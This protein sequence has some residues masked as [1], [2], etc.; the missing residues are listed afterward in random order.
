[1]AYLKDKYI[2]EVKTTLKQEY[3]SLNDHAIP[4]V[5]KVVVNMGVSDAKDNASILE[6]AV[7]NMTSLAGQKPVVTKAKR[8]ISA[9]KLTEGAPIGVMATL[10]GDRMYAFLEKLINV[11]LPKVRDFRG[12]PDTSF[13]AQGNY[14]LG[15]REL[16]IFPEID[17]KNLD[18][19]RGIQITITTSAQN[20]EQ[21]RRLLELLG[22]PF[23]KG[24]AN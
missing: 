22:M 15:L 6:K 9:F 8:S 19:P 11:V 10:R 21:G 2:K 4:R 13:D 7:L 16:S 12:I 14:N 23:K 5:L 20:Q 3:N 1:M 17:Y 18:R 24:G